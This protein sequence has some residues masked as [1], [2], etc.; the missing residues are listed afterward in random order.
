MSFTDRVYKGKWASVEMFITY[1]IFCAGLSLLALGIFYPLSQKIFQ[2]VTGLNS[3]RTE[4]GWSHEFAGLTKTERATRIA[5][6]T[7]WKTFG[8]RIPEPVR[9]LAGKFF[10]S[11]FPTPEKPIISLQ[12]DPVA[13]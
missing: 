11:L 10:P 1:W 2:A 12:D 7:F 5:E 3:M 13:N 4:H 9:N 8:E 6:Y